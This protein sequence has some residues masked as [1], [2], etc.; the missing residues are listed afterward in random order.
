MIYLKNSNYFEVEP[1]VDIF[2]I[3]KGK[4]TAL[5]FIPGWTLTSDVFEYQIEYYSK[6]Y[7]VI[8]I[9]PRSHGKSTVTMQ[10]N[11]Y[12]TH[13][14]DISK[15]LD[16][17]HLK[18]IIFVGWSFGGLETWGY[19]EKLGVSNVKA[20]ANIDITPKPLSDNEN[21]WN[22]GNFNNI[23]KNYTYG[24]NSSQN[25]RKYFINFTT[26]CMIQH[27]LSDEELDR[28]ISQPLHMPYYIARELYASGIF[29]DK[30]KGA[31]I[32]DRSI[33]S[34]MFI[35]ESRAGIGIPYMKK[36]YPNTKTFILGG[37]MMFWEYP[38]KFNKLLDSFLKDISSDS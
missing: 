32:A 17:L 24:M 27:K 31:E 1:G 34:C 22:A 10:G 18:D 7:R 35:S 25:F 12:D 28:I 37:H 38:D 4:G 11:D 2:Y 14:R 19:I 9:D 26:Q 8:A 36:H 20:L 29:S 23:S 6:N 16:Y 30:T 33:P 3:D 13:V 21:D 5:F 15:L